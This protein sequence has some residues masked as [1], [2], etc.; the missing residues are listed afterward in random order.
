MSLVLRGGR[1]IDQR[2][3]RKLD[4]EIGDDGRIAA[5]GTGL[6]GDVDLDASGCIVCS[7]FV[8]LHAHLH[9]HQPPERGVRCGPAI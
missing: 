1:V 9:L 7:G 5:V 2:G 8:D 6:F 3:E 4:V